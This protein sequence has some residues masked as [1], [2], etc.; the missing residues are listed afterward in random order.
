LRS[1]G[2]RRINLRLSQRQ[3]RGARYFEQHGKL[4]GI[5]VL[6]FVE[7]HNRIELANAAGCFGVLQKFI[8]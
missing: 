2:A 7:D 8:G 6:R 4:R 3:S 1:S 5:G